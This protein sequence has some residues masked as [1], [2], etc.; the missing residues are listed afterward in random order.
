MASFQMRFCRTALATGKSNCDSSRY[1]CTTRSTTAI[2][3][4]SNVFT[5]C[6]SGGYHRVFPAGGHGPAYGSSFFFHPSFSACRSHSPSSSVFFHSSSFLLSVFSVF[7][8]TFPPRG[9][10]TFPAAH[11]VCLL[12]HFYQSIRFTILYHSVGVQN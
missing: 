7:L 10:F 3:F 8:I 2:S 5:Q 11:L 1:R 4:K 9:E 12:L 6:P